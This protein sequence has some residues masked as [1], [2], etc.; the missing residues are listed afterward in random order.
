MRTHDGQRD[1]K[2]HLTSAQRHIIENHGTEPPGPASF[3]RS[4]GAI[5]DAPNVGPRSFPQRLNMKAGPAGRHSG[6]SGRALPARRRITD[7]PWSGRKSIA[8]N[9]RG[10]WGMSS[11]MVR[12]RP[13]CATASMV[14]PSISLRNL[15]SAF[16]VGM[17]SLCFGDGCGNGF[18]G[19]STAVTSRDVDVCAQKACWIFCGVISKIAFASRSCSFN[20][21][22]MMCRLR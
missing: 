6:T 11:R 8:P 1:E 21:N 13:D 5:I 2:P 22:P 15:R 17:M 19:P 16:H 10:I 4:A 12:N 18:F 3:M 20:G 9:V 14:R 7:T